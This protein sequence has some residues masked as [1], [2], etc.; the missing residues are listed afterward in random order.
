MRHAKKQE[1]MVHQQQEKQSLETVPEEAEMLHLS[2]TEI[3]HL[4][5]AQDLKESVANEQKETRKPIIETIDEEIGLR[6]LQ[7]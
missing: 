4:A 7:L 2:R 5:Y 6:H 1:R 3:N